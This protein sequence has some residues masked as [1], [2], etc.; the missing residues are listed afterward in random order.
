MGSLAS[1]LAL[2][3]AACNVTTTGDRG[4]VSFTP[5]DCGLPFCSLD[6][7]LAAGGSTAVDLSGDRDPRFLTL[8]SD[9]PAVAVTFPLP[10][11]RWQIMGVGPGRVTL[12]VLTPG[13][14]ELDTT[15][16]NVALPA[17]YGLVVQEGPAFTRAPEHPDEQIWQ[18]P[19]GQTVA[20]RVRPYDWAGFELMG[21]LNLET[22]IDAALFSRLSPTSDLASG[23]LAFDPMAPGD[24]WMSVYDEAG[25]GLDVFFEAR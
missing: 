18:I 6:D 14:R 23:E 17:S 3:T 2:F 16:I 11:D 5:D 24:Y 20:F 15:A 22:E 9:D 1:V 8:V 13:G 7:T 10:Y 21:K 4:I 12:A 25:L 19:S